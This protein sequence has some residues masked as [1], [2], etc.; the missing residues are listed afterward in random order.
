MTM[1]LNRG[2][3]ACCPRAV[4]LL[5]VFAGTPIALA[6]TLWVSPAG[7]EFPNIQ[8]AVTAAASGDT[9]YLAAGTYSGPGNI[10]IDFQGKTLSAIGAA[11]DAVFID[12]GSTARGFC[13]D[14]NQG[15]GTRIQS[16]TIINGNSTQLP[17]GAGG[18]VHLSSGHLTLV[19][20]TIRDCIAVS[21]GGVS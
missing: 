2:W 9:V 1:R 4:V 16:L 15:E 18:A 14:T 10:N 5:V 21:G 12:G 20:V 8:A 7:G 17:G 3:T 6:E 11:R 19:D 13:L